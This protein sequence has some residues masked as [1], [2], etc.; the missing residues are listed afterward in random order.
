MGSLPKL[1]TKEAYKYRKG[2]TNEGE[3]CRFCTHFIEK[4]PIFGI[5]NNSTTPIRI[6]SRCKIH[7]TGEGRRYRVQQDYRCDAQVFD[8]SKK[9][10]GKDA[11]TRI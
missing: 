5:G 3:N 11:A 4:F 1:K 6:E 8:E 9:T 2:S 10:W 7:G